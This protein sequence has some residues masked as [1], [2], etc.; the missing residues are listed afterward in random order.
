MRKVKV[1]KSL[2]SIVEGESLLNDAS[3]LV[4]FRFALAAVMTGQFR[5]QDAAVDFFLVIIMGALIGVIIGVIFYCYSSLAD[6]ITE[7]R[8]RFNPGYSLYHVLFR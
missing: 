8:D 1:P 6:H 3:S 2:M 4:V 5:F 7:H